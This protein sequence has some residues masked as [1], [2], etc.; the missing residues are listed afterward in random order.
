[1]AF[2]LTDEQLDRICERSPECGC[3]CGKCEA[4]AANMRYHNG[5]Y[6]D[7]EDEE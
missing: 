2:I 6:E 5:C 3:N 7:E 4:M 1:M